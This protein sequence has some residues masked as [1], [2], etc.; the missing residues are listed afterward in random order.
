MTESKYFDY[1]IKD[2]KS[3]N[4]LERSVLRKVEKSR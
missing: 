3:L 4:I 2:Q 1:K